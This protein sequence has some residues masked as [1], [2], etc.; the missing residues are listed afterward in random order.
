MTGEERQQNNIDLAPK[1]K[2]R[3][4]KIRKEKRS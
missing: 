2:T 1:M 4:M 3:R